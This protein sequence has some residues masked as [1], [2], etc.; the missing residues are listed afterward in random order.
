VFVADIRDE[1]VEVML[2]ALSAHGVLQEE[3]QE[4]LRCQRQESREGVGGGKPNDAP[5]TASK[6]EERNHTEA[7]S[8]DERRETREPNKARNF[9]ED[10][11]CLCSTNRKEERGK[12]KDHGDASGRARCNKIVIERH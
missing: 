12:R 6:R 2:K 10:G 5:T 1:K 9:E 11:A 4:H 8:E 3:L 7:N